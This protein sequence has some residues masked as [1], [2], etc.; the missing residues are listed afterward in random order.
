[1]DGCYLDYSGQVN[2]C[3]ELRLKSCYES[4]QSTSLEE[5]RKGNIL[6]FKCSMTNISLQSGNLEGLQ[7]RNQRWEWDK[8]VYSTGYKGVNREGEYQGHI[9]AK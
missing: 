1:M 6:S 9:S 5:T 4:S 2:I 7:S 3:C 8:C